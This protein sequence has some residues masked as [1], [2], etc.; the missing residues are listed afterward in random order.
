MKSKKWIAPLGASLLAFGA[1]SFGS[2]LEQQAYAANQSWDYVGE[3]S[4]G[5]SHEET[6]EYYR[7]GSY[8]EEVMSEPGTG[9]REEMLE[10]TRHSQSWCRSM[11][12]DM[13]Y[14]HSVI[15]LHDSQCDEARLGW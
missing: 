3:C 5:C 1:V 14:S 6:D 10:L 4:S 13:G 15:Y 8:Q 7:N 2:S 9:N 12:R 11:L